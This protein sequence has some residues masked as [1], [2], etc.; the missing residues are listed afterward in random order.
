M[1]LIAKVNVKH[2]DKGETAA[3]GEA[4]TVEDEDAAK[5]LIARGSA[6]TPADFEREQRANVT[7]EERIAELEVE[8][9]KTRTEL[10]KTKADR[11]AALESGSTPTTSGEKK[12]GPLPDD[13]PGRAALAEADINTYAQARKADF[14]QVPGIVDATARK[15][16]E[17][18]N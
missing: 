14:T 10:A 12:N 1:K 18:L 4:F 13:F 15:I 8:L 11:A 7:A 5:A 16:A 2:G 6:A 3:P 9:E 17:A